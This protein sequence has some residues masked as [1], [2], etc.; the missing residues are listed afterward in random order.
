MFNELKEE[1]KAKAYLEPRWATLT[2]FKIAPL[3]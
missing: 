3:V 2:L 1:V